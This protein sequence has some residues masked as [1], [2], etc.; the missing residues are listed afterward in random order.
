VSEPAGEVSIADRSF[1]HALRA[2]SAGDAHAV[3]ARLTMVRDEPFE[4]TSVELASQAAADALATLRREHAAQARPDLGRVHPSW[5]LRGLRA[6]TPAVR[7]AAVASTPGPL[8]AVLRAG[9]GLADQGLEPVSR[10]VP[11]ALTWVAALWTE[12]LVGD[13]PAR[14][15][16]PPVV[17]VLTA[18]SPRAAVRLVRTAALAKWAASRAEPPCLPALVRRRFDRLREALAGADDRLRAF[19]DRDVG[20]VRDRSRVWSRLGAVTVARLLSLAD[21][22]RVRWTLQHLPYT[23]AKALRGLMPGKPTA[24]ASWAVWEARV[25]AVATDRLRDEG[26]IGPDAEDGG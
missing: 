10:A 25:L 26:L 18:H 21:P 2:W 14:A 1:L 22:Y 15:D 9:L 6:E 7:R 12:R 19:A 20:A 17:R 3:C 4:R 16:D 11:A 24:G 23:K 5:C 8:Q 13:V